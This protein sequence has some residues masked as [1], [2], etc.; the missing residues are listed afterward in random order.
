MHSRYYVKPYRFQPPDRR[1]IWAHLARPYVAP[2][3]RRA[4]GTELSEVTGLEHLQASLDRQAGILLAANHCRSADPLVLGMAGARIRRFFYYLA[5]FHLFQQP[6]LEVWKLRGF[7][8]MSVLRDTADHQALR[9]CIQI[10]TEARRP[11][12]VFPEGTYYRRNDSVGP[13]QHGVSLICR[14]AAHAT[15]RPI[16]IHPVAIKYWF[17]DDAEAALARRVTRLELQ[18]RIPPAPGMSLLARVLRISD[19]ALGL[20][21][22]EFLGRTNAG[23]LSERTQQLAHTLL[24]SIEPR[25]NVVPEGSIIERVRRL[26]RSRVNRIAQLGQRRVADP[27]LCHE[28]DIL[29]LCQLLFSQSP[30]YLD[31]APSIERIGETVQRLEEDWFDMDC[32]VAPMTA[33]VQFGPAID[34]RAFSDQPARRDQLTA[35]LGEAMSET[36]AQVVA[37]GR[38]TLPRRRGRRTTREFQPVHPMISLDEAIGRFHS[39]SAAFRGWE[40]ALGAS[41]A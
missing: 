38:P 22:Q 19:H 39:S 27:T 37:R 30:D 13:L 36:L 1:T 23:T 9:A 10:L 33:V 18:F 4:F 26:R 15:R 5:S 29:Y 14:R 35:A 31:G 11:L 8:A 34:A 28:M 7:G 41:Q 12:V 21:E 17:I 25:D 20:W 3:V 32:P 16:V 6:R 24:Q 40:A 2:Y